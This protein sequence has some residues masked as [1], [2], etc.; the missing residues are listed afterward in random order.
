MFFYSTFFF[1]FSH[2]KKPQSFLFQDVKNHTNIKDDIQYGIL[3]LRI[4]SGPGS[5]AMSPV[6]KLLPQS[7]FTVQFF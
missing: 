6:Y 4:L 7:P 1:F 2:K 3:N 5:V